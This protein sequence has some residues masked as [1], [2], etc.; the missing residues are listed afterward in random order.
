MPYKDPIKN[1]AC[2]AK[3]YYDNVEECR[4]RSREW[5]KKHKAHVKKK[6]HEHYL[7]N[8]AKVIARSA[9]WQ[10]AN[11]EADKRNRHNMYLRTKAQRLAYT[12]KWRANKRREHPEY[13]KAQAQR[14][15]PRKLKWSKS[16]PEK[17]KRFRKSWMDKY[18][19][20]CFAKRRARMKKAKVGDLK[21]IQ[22]FYRWLRTV[23]L[24]TCFWC[25]KHI[26]K[27]LRHADHYM[28]LAKGGKH[29]VSNLVPACRSCNCSKN[30]K[31]PH[32]F[33]A[34]IKQYR[35]AA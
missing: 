1:A 12:K 21:K 23:E 7:K 24:V 16:N 26:P 22:K 11:P 3:W 4:R 31:L 19:A 33:K 30:A 28:P 15:Y 10:K 35:I 14:D 8:R 2:K 13:M 9:A 29:C 25:H 18:G 34:W 32:E 27:G 20:A 17:I 5:A 6:Q